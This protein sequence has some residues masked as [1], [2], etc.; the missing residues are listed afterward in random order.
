MDKSIRPVSLLGASFTLLLVG[1]ALFTWDF[2]TSSSPAPSIISQPALPSI[3]F[4]PDLSLPKAPENLPEPA[5]PETETAST[6]V[7]LQSGDSLSKVLN[8]LGIDDKQI[9][10]LVE[11]DKDNVLNTLQPGNKLT[12]DIIQPLSELKTLTLAASRQLTHI[13]TATDSGFQYQQKVLPL[14][15]VVTYKEAS[16]QNSLFVDGSRAGINEKLLT[17]IANIFRW[18]I[19][20]ALDI[21]K[22]DRFAVLFEEQYVGDDK[23]GV[24]NIL[25]AKFINN[26]RIYEA[27]RYDTGE[28]GDFYTTDGLS[29]K[30][31]FVRAPVDYTRITSKF[32]PNRLH[33]IFKTTRPHQ[34]IDYAAAIGT[35]VQTSGNGKI[36]FV[37]EM[38]GYGNTVIVDHGNGY[39]TLYAHLSKFADKMIAGRSVKQGE[40]IAYVGQ[41]GWATGPHLHYEF[42]INGVYQN[43]E[44]VAIP[45]DNPLT[46]KQLKEYLPYAQRMSQQL[47]G[48]QSPNFTNYLAK[49]KRS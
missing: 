27:V 28:G 24:G 16:I 13:F 2:T 11:V 31:A 48:S 23:V 43:P 4:L 38:K 25:A 46:K 8:R 34:G 17:Q 33:P 44:T 1:A 19:D 39:T 47:A 6:T 45:H 35:P 49:L 40:T 41:T 30:K 3:G 37:G 9:A 26:G 29:L 21:R 36:Q 22:G 15:T 20:F 42:R 14:E 18:D 12:A 5:A 10:A 7:K 32:N